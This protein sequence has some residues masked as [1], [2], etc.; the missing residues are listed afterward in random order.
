MVVVVIV[1]VVVVIIGDG[2]CCVG[3]DVE[4]EGGDILT[5]GLIQGHTGS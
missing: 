1:M 3:N 4:L 2:G 5:Q